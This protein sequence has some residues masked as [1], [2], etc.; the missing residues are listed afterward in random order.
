MNKRR[1][2]SWFA[3]KASEFRLPVAREFLD[4]RYVRIYKEM[5]DEADASSDPRLHR[6]AA[7]RAT[8]IRAMTP[9][10]DLWGLMN[11][12][13]SRHLS[14]AHLKQL[15]LRKESLSL[16]KRVIREY[17]EKPMAELEPLIAALAPDD[18]ADDD[19]VDSDSGE[20]YLEKD[21]K[22]RTS[23]L[24]PQ[25]VKDHQAK[26]KARS[27]A[28]EQELAALDKEDE[29][30]WE[31]SQSSARSEFEMALQEYVGGWISADIDERDVPGVASDAADNFFYLYPEWNR[32]AALLNM[33]KRDIKEAIVDYIHDALVTHRMPN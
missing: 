6:L 11:D 23:Q 22:A 1:V 33:N 10:D 31:A 17:V 14:Q 19:Y 29:V 24:H 21:R 26:R 30:D 20:I 9:T 15:K 12:E 27:D 3:H 13:A 28:R 16:L 7:E 8:Q 5:S 4:A 32:W 25:Y 2:K 18:V